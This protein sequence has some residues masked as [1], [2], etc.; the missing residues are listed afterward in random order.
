MV[1]PLDLK[2]LGFVQPPLLPSSVTLPNWAFDL[3]TLKVD[4][5]NPLLNALNALK[6][7]SPPL[8]D[9][10]SVLPTVDLT[11][12]ILPLPSVVPDLG[13]MTRGGSASTR[14]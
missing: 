14:A 5:P 11:T 10:S 6:V 4:L 12:L 13:G 2:K 7:S 3:P 1:K 8:S 9:L